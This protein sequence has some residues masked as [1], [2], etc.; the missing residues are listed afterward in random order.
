MAAACCATESCAAR[1]S[2]AATTNSAIPFACSDEGRTPADAPEPPDAPAGGVGGRLSLDGTSEEGVG[3]S[4][5]SPCA[6]G[7]VVGTTVAAPTA[8][9]LVCPATAHV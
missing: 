8:A 5:S 1:N 7:H 4:P 9:P 2:A 6:R 3:G